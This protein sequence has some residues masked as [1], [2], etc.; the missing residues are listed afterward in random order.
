MLILVGAFT[1]WSLVEVPREGNNNLPFGI[2]LE[3]FTLICVVFIITLLGIWLLAKSL[4]NRKWF[5]LTSQLLLNSLERNQHIGII[6]AL[7]GIFIIVGFNFI[8]SKS[9]ITEPVTLAYYVRLRPLI[10]AGIIF[11]GQTILVAFF[12]KNGLKLKNFDLMNRGFL[13][14][15]ISF[16]IIFLIWL[17]IRYTGNGITAVDEGVGWHALGTPL[18]EVQVLLAWIITIVF[19]AFTTWLSDNHNSS[20]WVTFIQK[21]LVICIVLWIGA[22]SFWMAQPLKP[23]W[24]ASEPRPPNFEFYPNSDSSVYDVTAQNLLLGYGFKTRGSPFTLR[25]LYG[26]VLAGFHLLSGTGYEAIIWMQV[27]VLALIPVILYFVA[28]QIHNKGSGILAALV[29]IMREANAIKLGDSISEAHVKLLLPFLPT[30]LGILLFIYFM[31]KWLKN[32]VKQKSLPIFLGGLTG[33]FM[34]VRPEFI[35]LLLFTGLAA[36]FQIRKT[37]RVLYT[38]FILIAAGMVVTLSPWIYR[39]YQLTGTIFIDS[40]HYRLDFISKRFR[41]NPIGFSDPLNTPLQSETV[42]PNPISENI[43]LIETPLLPE[44]TNITTPVATSS[45]GELI[46]GHTEELADDVVEFVQENPG[47]A[48]GFIVNHL[49]NSIVQTVLQLPSTYPI[50]QSTI[51]WLDHKSMN[52]FWLDCCSLVDYERRFPFW[53]KWNG[54]LPGNSII[55]VTLNLFL[56]AIGISVSWNHSKFIGL[57]PLFGGFGYIL[58]NAMVR[59]SGGRYIV[60]VNWIGI[61]YFSIG[62][63]HVTHLGL[64]II[65]K[66]KLN[67]MEASDYESSQNNESIPFFTL[68]NLGIALGL[69]LFGCTL[70]ILEITIPEKYES[71]KLETEIHSLLNP[72]NSIFNEQE[73]GF[74][75]SLINSGGTFLKGAAFYPR[76]HKPYQMGSVWNYYQDRPY[77]HLDFYLSSPSDTGVVLALDDPP[78]YFPN[79][80]DVFVLACLQDDY[81][82]SLLIIFHPNNVQ[83]VAIWRSTFYD[84]PVCPLPLP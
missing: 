45:E 48:L 52:Q 22:F 47:T 4:I 61:F 10:L 54:I 69:F 66:N 21:D 41:A 81:Q 73:K 71:T 30:A 55:P 67:K 2:S 38:G 53:P 44:N 39:N 74:I 70:P 40:P 75:E 17:W 56:I 13:S 15:V 83:P 84:P 24:F 34:L 63:I 58:I 43:G 27:A 3:R 50:T 64:S 65:Q 79:G 62:I 72:E 5:S 49:M 82:D 42:I 77:A 8:F 29:L 19:L 11:S 26:M 33:I 37:P 46:Q 14:V 32:P 35:V 16:G 6:F 18:L 12:L 25:P 68:S 36:L 23:N 1:L 57:T 28:K 78:D 76:H 20:K 9:A 59:N 7:C 60:P 80:S 51:K 31:N